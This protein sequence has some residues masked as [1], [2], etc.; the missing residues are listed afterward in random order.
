[1]VLQV[2]PPNANATARN[3][4]RVEVRPIDSLRQD[5][6]NPRKHSAGQIRQIARS[7]STFGMNVPVLI[8]ATD[9]IVAGHGRLAAL[10]Q[11]GLSE[12]PTIR[13]DHLTPEQVRAFAIAENKL[14]L[15]ASWDET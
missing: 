10:K 3:K 15:N 14:G 4:P 12:V 11:L 9:K 2:A 8:D 7:I 5:P 6:L 1:M 13:L